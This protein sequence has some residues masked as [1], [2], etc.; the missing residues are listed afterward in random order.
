LCV[1]TLDR[2]LNK[3][4]E[5][6]KIWFCNSTKLSPG[7]ILLM[8]IIECAGKDISH[9]FDPKTKDVSCNDI[10]GVVPL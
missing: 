1:Y 5:N 7:D 3:N 8:A 6:K 4:T 10:V 9:W 2:I